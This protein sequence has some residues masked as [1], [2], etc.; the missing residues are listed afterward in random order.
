MSHTG[1]INLIFTNASGT[2]FSTYTATAQYKDTLWHHAAGTFNS[3]TGVIC[4][5][6][7]GVLANTATNA[8]FGLL[9]NNTTMNLVF[10]SD[11]AGVAS[12]TDRQFRGY[13]S[14]VR[15]WNVVRSASEIA[16]NYRQRLI[17]NESGL[18]GYWK[19]NQGLGTGWGSYSTALDSTSN[20]S[21]G[22]LS[23]SYTHLT[24]PTKRIV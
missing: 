6:I 23:V 1:E 17:G 9:S 5:Y 14:D 13:L 11:H 4:L 8:A 24:L 12:Q 15:L 7:D 21:H 3:N 10:G 20:R 22:T 18:V 16:A 19:F 2:W